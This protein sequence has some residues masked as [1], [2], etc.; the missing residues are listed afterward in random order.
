MRI[1]QV[2]DSLHIGGAEKMAVNYANSLSKMIEFSAIVTTREEGVL[3]KQ[4]KS[5]VGY[6]FLKKKR[7]LDFKAFWR[8]RNYCKENKIDFVQ[9]H[10]SS[11]FTAFFLK[12]MYPK[13]QIIWHNHYGLS[14]FLSWKRLLML[15]LASYCFH[16]IIAVNKQL[17]KW[18][19]N[20]LNCKNVI[21]LPNYTNIDTLSDETTILKGIQGKRILSLANL[22]YQ[23]NHFLLLEVAEKLKASH[24]DWSF[25]LVGNDLMDDYSAQI[26]TII[27]EKKLENVFIYGTKNDTANI[28][29]QSEITILTSDSEGLPVA[30]I[31]YGL[32]SKCTL[33]TAVGEIPLI[34][35][36]G[37]NGFVVPVK[38]SVSFYEVLVSLIKD[39]NLRLKTGQ[40]L[41]RT[42]LEKNSEKSVVKKYLEWLNNDHNG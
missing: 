39:E 20:K 17:E 23:K 33:S 31:E 10:S 5:D 12:I 13:I 4:I 30:I 14:E 22:R 16:G 27:N 28:I 21:Y 29:K 2:I 37:E 34:I 19:K 7:K 26:K 42:I 41:Y 6:L 1:L 15:Q 40:N 35:Q 3:K 24:P 32:L 8:L 36:N 18:A 25:H 9:S 11:Y 38:D